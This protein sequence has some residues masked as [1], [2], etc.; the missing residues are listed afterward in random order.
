[1]IG[2]RDLPPEYSAWNV[3][4]GAPNGR[5]RYR[6]LPFKRSSAVTRVIGPFGW[7]WNSSTRRFEYPWAYEQITRHG[8]GLTVVDVGG[9]VSGLQF[10]LGSEGHRVFTVDPAL[11]AT[12][13]G[14]PLD[15][16]R[17][18][19]L[20]RLYKASVEVVQTTIQ[21]AKLPEQSTDVVLSISAIEH[22]SQQ[23]ILGFAREVDRILKPNGVVVLTIDLFIDLHP[24]TR[25]TENEW[26]SNCDVAK[27]LR[28]AGL[29]LMTGRRDELFG[30]PE[31]DPV[32]I[33]ER[34]PLYELNPSGPCVAQCLVAAKA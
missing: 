11:A 2:L 9:S 22:F 24:F 32:T 3:K 6:H 21:E 4:W 19:Q 15:R 25:K 29:K 5:R 28:D 12:G 18:N 7:Q 14:W 8:K 23:D 1:M 27:L 13:K 17:H 26:G 20:R 16:V 10:V 34:L 31:F 33:L 30:H